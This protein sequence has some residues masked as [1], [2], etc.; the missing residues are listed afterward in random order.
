MPLTL[1]RRVVLVHEVTL[2]QL[3]RQARLSHATAAYDHQLILSEKLRAV[4]AAGT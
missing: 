1:N 2:N 3:D 4:S